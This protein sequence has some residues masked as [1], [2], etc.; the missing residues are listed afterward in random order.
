MNARKCKKITRHLI[1]LHI[2][3]TTMLNIK[4]YMIYVTCLYNISHMSPNINDSRK[5]ITFCLNICQSILISFLKS[6]LFGQDCFKVIVFLNFSALLFY[7]SL[8]ELC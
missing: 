2:L 6:L 7:K 3:F 4:F 5:K 8:F 1:L